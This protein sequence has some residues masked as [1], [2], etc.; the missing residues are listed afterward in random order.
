MA[1]GFDIAH[2]NKGAEKQYPGKLTWYV[3]ATC[4]IAALG[5]LIFGY[6][7]G[8]SGG[9]TSMDP[10]LERFFPS[11]YHKEKIDTST[12]Q[13]C[14]FDDMKLT[15]FTSSLY[16]AALVASFFASWVTRRLGR[17]MSMLLGG[18]IFFVGAAINASSVNIGM[19]IAGRLL[20]GVGVGFSN[21]SVPLYV[22]EMAPSKHRGSL[23]VV[24]QLAITIGIFA[25]NLVNYFTPMIKS[26]SGW[27]YSLGGAMVPSLFIFIS[28]FFLP[29]T[30]NSMLEKGHND[31]AREMLKRIRGV[32]D[33][34]VEE[35]FNDILA[36]SEASKLVKNPWRNIIKRQYRPQLTMA[37]LIPFFQQFTGINVVMFYAPVLFKTIGFGANAS[38]GSSLITGAINLL[39]T[40][41]SVY[42][43]D[44]WGRRFLFLEG[45]IQLFVFQVL[46]GALIGWKFGVT[47][48]VTVLPKWYAILVVIL[49]CT[50]VAGF[51][52]SWGP[53]GWLVP[54]EIFPLEI[55]SAAQSI[56]VSVNMF[57]TFI[58]AQLFLTMLCHLK[59]GL[60]FFFAFFV[61]VMSVF[62]YFFLPE[63][64]NIP[65]EEMSRVWREHWFWKRFNSEEQPQV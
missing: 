13:Y 12:N 37:I 15:L 1:G 39:A 55:R 31:K 11:V 22:S 42:G 4:I 17:R 19:L 58:V 59:F 27:R 36:A 46:L 56:V 64:K 5:G 50:Y 10:F 41:V 60:F 23:N 44:K 25:A 7:L 8:I 47:G 9:V 49:I 14:K 35:E 16:L 30:P 24:F 63:T 33:K 32:T 45:G 26:G 3:R 62:I 54:S 61:A 18:L 20:L 65:I 40:F 29:N 57:F 48:D 6:D 34:E 51:A 52:W 28:G 53:L 43:I 21:Q 2:G 38:L